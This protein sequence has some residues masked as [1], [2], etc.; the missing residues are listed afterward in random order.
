MIRVESRQNGALR[1]LA[2]LARDKKYRRSTGELACEGEKMLTEALTS[3]VKVRTV[4]VREGEKP[5]GLLERAEEQGAAL[6]TAPP[7]LFALASDVETP[8]GVIFSCESPVLG[9]SLP[10]VR[11]AMLLDGVQDPGN[12]GT[13]VRTAEAF[14]LDAL[15]LC[16][17]CADSTAPKVLRG[18]MGSIFRQPLYRLPL[19]EAA[20][21][22][23][24]QGLPVYAAALREDSVPLPELPLG[25]CAFV[26]GSEGHGVRAETVALSDRTVVIP[27]AGR[28]ESLNA[29]VAAS[30]LLWELY[31]ANGGAAG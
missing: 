16:E 21:Q 28:T 8:Q 5:D 19:A 27:M 22:L 15:V 18:T 7:Q 20:V 2:R 14:G 31:R 23:R 25:R 17:G 12:I 29:G 26:V 3:G 1:H 30:V 6:Y 24:A 4:L 10:P 11:T 13:I 9:G